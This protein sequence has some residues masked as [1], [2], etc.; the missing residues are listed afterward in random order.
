MNALNRA[1]IDESRAG[2]FLTAIFA[3][4]TP[5]ADGFRLALACGGHPPPVV[6]D[7][8]GVRRALE[9]TGTLLGVVD[10]PNIADTEIE[11]EPGDT[12]LFYTDGL[13]EA[14]APERT[15]STPEVAEL[16]AEVRGDTAAQTAEGCL[17]SAIAAGGGVTR[18]DI[19]VLVV[20]VQIGA[21]DRREKSGEGIFDTG[22]ML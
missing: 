14:S 15:L 11:L 12:L 21:L 13:T 5:R 18:D 16:L 10:D 22:T 17:S 3:R 8:D 7:A 19:A 9:C 1:V 4:V 20:Q 2:Q 6:I